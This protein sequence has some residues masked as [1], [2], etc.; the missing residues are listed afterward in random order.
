VYPPVLQ[1]GISKAKQPVISYG[2]RDETRL[3]TAGMAG[4]LSPLTMAG[5][6]DTNMASIGF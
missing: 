1:S 5:A 2:S 6:E 3:S 4:V